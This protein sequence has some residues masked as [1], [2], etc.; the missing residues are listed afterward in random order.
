M[1]ILEKKKDMKMD[2]KHYQ[3]SARCRLLC[4]GAFPFGRNSR[5]TSDSPLAPANQRVQ[6]AE[7]PRD[8]IS[9]TKPICVFECFC[10]MNTINTIS[11]DTS[12]KV[13]LAAACRNKIKF[14]LLLF[15]WGT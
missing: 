7:S 2:N 9:W 15:S 4:Y 6:F 10:Y 8:Y 5:I 12:N 1:T 14:C 11:R 13:K 3:K